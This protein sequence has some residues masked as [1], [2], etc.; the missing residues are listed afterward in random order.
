MEHE[1]TIARHVIDVSGLPENVLSSRAP[2]W[3]GVILMIIIEGLMIVI[4]IATYFYLRQHFT[5]WPPPRTAPP[6]IVKGS[7]MTAVLLL[8]LIPAW[9]AERLAQRGGSRRAVVGWLAV[10][11]LFCLATIYLRAVEFTGLDCRW[12]SHAYGSVVWTMLGVHALHIISS[13]IETIVLMVYLMTHP[14]DEKHRLD[15][16]L[17]SVYWY[18]IVGAW[19]ACYA[20]IYLSPL[21]VEKI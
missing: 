19:V 8:S 21:L 20:V 17:N 16:A 12:D 13:A 1:R 5:Q 3:W 11:A 18:F 15:T 2:L 4:L 10:A 14:L 7:I 9:L 6:D